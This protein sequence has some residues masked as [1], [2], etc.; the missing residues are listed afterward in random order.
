MRRISHFASSIN[1]VGIMV[2]FSKHVVSCRK[3]E[4]VAMVMVFGIVLLLPCKIQGKSSQYKIKL[5]CTFQVVRIMGRISGSMSSF[6][7]SISE[8]KAEEITSLSC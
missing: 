5:S 4:V 3:T 2:F 1:S 6:F 7:P 8:E